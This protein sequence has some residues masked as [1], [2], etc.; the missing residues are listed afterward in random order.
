MGDAADGV[1]GGGL[2]GEG[3]GK[4]GDGLVTLF[5]GTLG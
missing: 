2:F 1:L 4:A 3:L 5:A